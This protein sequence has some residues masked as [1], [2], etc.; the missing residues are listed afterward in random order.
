V[1][2]SSGTFAPAFTFSIERVVR[3]P[4]CWFASEVAQEEAIIGSQAKRA[5]HGASA[6]ISDKWLH[7]TLEAE[8]GIVG[9]FDPE[10]VLVRPKVTY[11]FSDHW[12]TIVG[13]EVYR[14]SDQ[15]VFG[16]L[17]RNSVG[18]VEGRFSF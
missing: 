5:Q 15:S 8:I 10:G 13:G 2:K 14:G 12:K 18:Y 11:S 4:V 16:L 17:R 6:R 9:Y 3:W 7:E 1:N